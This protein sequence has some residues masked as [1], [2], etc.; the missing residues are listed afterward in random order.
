MFDEIESVL[1][2]FSS[3]LERAL[4]RISM[5]MIREA[6]IVD[7]WNPD[8]ADEEFLPWLAY[9]VSVDDWD[10]TWP[11]DVRRDVIRRSIEVHRRKGTRGAVVRAVEALGIDAEVIEWFEEGGPVHTFGVDLLVEDLDGSGISIG[12]DLLASANRQIDH[13]K[14]VRSHYSVRVGEIVKTGAYLRVGVDQEHL[15]DFYGVVDVGSVQP[16]AVV[17]VRNLVELERVHCEYSVP[18]LI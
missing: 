18:E 1:P 11:E 12:A 3:N 10:S 7:V 13:V 16:H 6:R 17:S 8:T 14:P 4:E 9:S 15:N 5:K 2:P